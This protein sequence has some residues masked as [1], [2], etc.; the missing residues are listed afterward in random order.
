MVETYAEERQEEFRHPRQS[1]GGDYI[2]R[3][4]FLE[5]VEDRYGPQ[6]FG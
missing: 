3:D 4:Q 6:R 5:E 1:G 2:E